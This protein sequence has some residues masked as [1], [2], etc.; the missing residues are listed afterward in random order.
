MLTSFSKIKCPRVCGFI[1]WS[2][3]WI[4]WLTSLSLYEYKY[5]EYYEFFFFNYYSVV[6]LEIKYYDSSRLPFILQDPVAILGFR[7]FHM[8]MRISLSKSVNN[9]VG[10]L[11]GI[12][13]TV[14][15][16]GKMAIFTM[17]IL[18]IYEQGRSFHLLIYSS[19]S[20]FRDLKFLSYRSFTCLVRV[21]WWYLL[22]LYAIF[23]NMYQGR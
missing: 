23:M 1:S 13:L 7:F 22:N 21:F 14:D 6:Q 3:I 16:F 20:F 15:L 9:F 18:L 4:H 17:L 19:V 8:K 2:S 10:I 5:Y 12:S 11:M